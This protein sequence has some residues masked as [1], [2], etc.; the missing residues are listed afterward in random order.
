MLAGH[1]DL[2]CPPELNLLPFVSMAGRATELGECRMERYRDIGLHPAQGLVRALMEL[3]QVSAEQ[4]CYI[5]EEWVR[6]DK[7]VAAL[8][9]TILDLAK[10]RV[11]VDKSTL[12]ATS[13]ETLRR[14]EELFAKPL[15]VY[16]FRHPYSVIESLVRNRY[17]CGPDRDPVGAAEALWARTNSNIVQFLSAIEP[18]RRAQVRYEEL[19]QEPESTMRQLCDFLAIP[20]EPATL[21]PYRELRMTDGVRPGIPGLGD[22][23]F[24]RHGAIDPRLGDRWRRI[25]VGPPL[26]AAAPIA[27]FLGYELPSQ[28]QTAAVKC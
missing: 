27:Q 19:V 22:A 8:Y 1:A 21:D 15:Y 17:R 18:Q 26:T 10:P 7:P 2:F 24:L 23:D 16:L 14:A 12:Y 3:E 6:A 11:L 20:F 4:S 13:L 9:T 5:V 25:R 28:K